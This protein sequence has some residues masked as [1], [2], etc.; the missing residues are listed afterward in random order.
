MYTNSALTNVTI[1]N[2]NHSGL[3]NHAIDTITIHMVVGQCTAKSLGEFFKSVKHSSNYGIGYDGSIGLYVEEKNRSWCSS[4]AANDHR[5]ITIEVASDTKRPYAVTDKAYTALI[6]LLVDICVRNNIKELKWKADKSLVGHVDEQNMTIHQW[7]DSTD[8]PGD[9][10]LERHAD[11]ANKVN[12]RLIVKPEE[13]E[14]PKESE[15]ETPEPKKSYEEIARE[16]AQLKWGRAGVWEKRVAK[17]GY[18]PKLVKAALN[19]LFK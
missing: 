13:P 8:C 9:F 10:L 14:E 6:N 15:V 17:A 5:A 19:K 1:F 2:N 16:V 3:R 18:H 4:S 12:D 11:I 7:F